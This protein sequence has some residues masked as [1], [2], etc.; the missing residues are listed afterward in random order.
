LTSYSIPTL[1]MASIC[2]T[3]TLYEFLSW[4]RRGG[5]RDG[6]AFALTGLGATVF[7]VGC[8]GQYNVDLPARSVPWLNLQVMALI[9]AG[10]AF[11]W[12]VSEVT[13]SVRR[14][15][16]IITLAWVA[17]CA[18]GQF[19]DLGNLG[20]ITERP[21][22]E[23]VRLPGGFEFVYKHVEMG[24]LIALQY[25]AGVALIAYI[26]WAVVKY[27]RSGN[28]K[29][30]RVL[31]IVLGLFCTALTNDFAIV[32]GLYSSINLLEYAWLVLLLVV[33]LRR[34][35]EARDALLTK[36]ALG[37][38][39]KKLRESRATLSAIVDSTPDLI[40]SVDA[41][42]FGLLSF[43][44]GMRE[45]FARNRGL[46]LEVGMTPEEFAASEEEILTWREFYARA[47]AEGSCQVELETRFG[48][49]S[50]PAVM[51]FAISVIRRE[52]KVFGLS[53]FGKDVTERRRAEEQIAKSLGEKE[54]LIRELYHRTKNNMNVII[55]MLR[56]QANRVGDERLR[57]AFAE[58]EARIMSMSLVHE[59][60]YESS[61]LSRINLKTYIEDLAGRLFKNYSLAGERV[62]LA[63]D[64]RDVYVLIDTAVSCGLI[65]NELISNALKYAFPGER[66][67]EIRIVLEKRADSRIR[68][69]FSDDGV[70]LPE[71]F[72]TERDGHLGMKIVLS[73]ARRRLKADVSTRSENG[74]SYE[75]KFEEEP[76]EARA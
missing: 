40:W 32:L 14:R 12:Y 65:V 11:L 42:R 25:A 45:H 72:D 60:L 75:V 9:S 2:S 61:D 62:S 36:N 47:L 66:R 13:G 39:E 6:L 70:G 41:E 1:I 19:V 37:E 76:E 23:R 59:K 56:L 28:R 5:K 50:R 44:S 29:E 69:A 51:Q 21:I 24:P 8:C 16:L 63:L 3:V 15:Y 71:G 67:G 54:T 35:S 53:V 30:A 20:W 34:S 10:A 38:S 73:L 26:T 4:S 74:L 31:L 58:T 68:L 33:G 46:R 52:G 7:C 43:N 57:E 17:L 49:G 18:M 64:L 27:R 48:V 55:S 22:V